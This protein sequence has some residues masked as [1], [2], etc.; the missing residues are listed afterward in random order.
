M[1]EASKALVRSAKLCLATNLK[2]I[3][4]W[5]TGIQ[6][7]DWKPAV[8]SCNTEKDDPFWSKGP[9]SAPYKPPAVILSR[10][11]PNRVTCFP[12]QIE[13]HGAV[14]LKH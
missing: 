2:T 5:N 8:L 14:K 11:P 9:A 7:G 3:N 1:N 10:H 12:H 13:I 4:T 6:V